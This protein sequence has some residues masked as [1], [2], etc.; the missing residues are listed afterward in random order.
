MELN[1][2]LPVAQII[3]VTADGLSL[4]GRSLNHALFRFSY[5]RLFSLR[6]SRQTLFLSLMLN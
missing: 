6:F 1:Y 4:T 5:L 3:A 2:S